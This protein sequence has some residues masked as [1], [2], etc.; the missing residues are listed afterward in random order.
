M[1]WAIERC[2]ERGCS[3]VQLTSDRTRD[4]AHRFYERL[5]FVGTH[6]GFK[7]LFPTA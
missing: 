5:G 1:R 4:A 2:K 6:T 7:L 3:V